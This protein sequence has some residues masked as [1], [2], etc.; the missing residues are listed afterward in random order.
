MEF[1]CPVQHC[2][3]C[4]YLAYAACLLACPRSLDHAYILVYGLLLFYFEKN[5]EGYA[6]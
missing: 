3:V 2:T 5:Y 4:A 6:R 1:M